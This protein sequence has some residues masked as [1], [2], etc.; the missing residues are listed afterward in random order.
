[1]AVGNAMDAITNI[2][3]IK[4]AHSTAVELNEIILNNGAVLVAVTAAAI[5]TD[6]AYMY[7]GKMSMPKTAALAI[8][9]MDKV[10]WDDTAKEINKTPTANTEC[11]YCVDKSL[12]A[13][14]EVVMWL[15]P[16]LV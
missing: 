14:T 6:N 13:D 5:S 15:E 4:Y 10:Y 9:Q 11:G 12:A 8:D 16:K 3:T 7:K 1:M 2:R